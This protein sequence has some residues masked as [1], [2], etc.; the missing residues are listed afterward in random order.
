MNKSDFDRLL[1]PWKPAASKT[2][3]FTNANVIDPVDGKVLPQCTVRMARGVIQSVGPTTAATTA[4]IGSQLHGTENCQVLPTRPAS[5]T[6][7]S[8][9]SN[10]NVTLVDLQGRYLCP[11][12]IDNHVHLVSV[13]GANGLSETFKLTPDQSKMRQSWKCKQILS[14]GFTSVRDCGGASLALKQAIAEGVFPGP[15]LF[16][17]GQALSQTGGHADLRSGLEAADCCCGAT[18]GVQLGVISDGVPQCLKNARD[19]FRTGA[20]FLKIM[21]S[22]G[23]ASPTDALTNVQF[24]PEEIQAITSVAR[25]YKSFATAHAYTIETVR[26]AI[27]NGVKSIEHG[28]MI[29]EDTARYMAENDVFLT[30]TLIAYS[31]MANPRWGSFLPP[32]NARKNEAVLNAGFESLRIASRAGVTM[33]Y[34][35]DL[36]GPLDIAQTKEFMLRAQVLSPTAILQSATIN[37]A[38]LLGKADVLGQIRR[39]FTADALILTKNPLEDISVLDDPEHNLLAVIKDGH[40]QAS[41]WSKLPVDFH[42]P[43]IPIE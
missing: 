37:P 18:Y 10:E 23:V 15:R 35:T 43:M 6:S 1:H 29:D 40:V 5:S 4:T 8:S 39:G 22:G 20:D 16:I 36:L 41:R 7:L 30:P 38:R 9:S 24:T 27:D 25:S 32:E 33:C 2:Y 13:P 28:N 3:V 21:A 12:L 34:G 19:Q 11:G 14:R 42:E 17:A 31:E 26:Q